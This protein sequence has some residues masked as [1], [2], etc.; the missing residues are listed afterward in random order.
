VRAF[1]VSKTRETYECQGFEVC[2]DDVEQLGLFVEVEH[3]CKE[4]NDKTEALKECE[5]F[6]NSIAPGAVLEP[7]KYGDLMQE[8]INKNNER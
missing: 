2:L 5:S 1:T 4:D 8:I 3:P 6:L 7:K